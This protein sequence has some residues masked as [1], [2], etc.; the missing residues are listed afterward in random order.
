MKNTIPQSIF[1]IYLSSILLPFNGGFINGV[2]LVSFLH[3]SVGYVTGNLVFAGTSFSSSAYALFLHLMA[4]VA[5][6]LIGAIISG[7]MIRSE[8]YHKD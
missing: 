1:W 4:L 5:C 3:N 8:Y 2:T 7:L 6:F